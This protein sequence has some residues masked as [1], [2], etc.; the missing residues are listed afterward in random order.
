MIVDL[1]HLGLD[2]G[3]QIIVKHAI[4][5][6][7]PG[8]GVDICGTDPELRVH[9]RAWCR[10]RGHRY[11]DRDVDGA[12]ARVTRGEA[13]GA[14][15]RNSEP[16]GHASLAATGAIVERP[17]GHWGVAPR[18]SQVE[19][20]GPDPYFALDDKYRVWADEA[21]RLYAQAAASQWD[22]ATAIGWATPLTHDELIEAAV[23]Q[24]MTY[25]IE[26]EV[27]ALVVPARFIAQVHPHFREVMQLLAIQVAD[28]ARHI[29]AFTRRA[30]LS[31]RPLGLSTVGGRQS[32]QTLIDEPD[33]A[34]STFLLSVLGE[35]TFLSLLSFLEAHAPDPITRRVAQLALQ[36]EARHVAFGIAHLRVQLDAEPELRARLVAAVERRH[37]ALA[38]TSGLNDE[39]FD[40]LVLLAAGSL[41]PSAIASGWHRVQDL[42]HDMDLGRR[43]RLARLGFSPA[44][45]EALSALHTRNFM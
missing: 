38:Q 8:A 45:A 41:D 9:L 29:E 33:F 3:A 44:A 24:V 10:A 42:Q 40:G 32:L 19:L 16:A 4:E 11:E 21:P 28:E 34:I 13:A 15:R 37:D 20:G 5:R 25:L 18:G 39:V 43:R 23:I 6:L 14:P 1:G 31:G 36:D 12:I 17:P 27:A 7:E 35:G 22:P 26:N 2:E 30:M